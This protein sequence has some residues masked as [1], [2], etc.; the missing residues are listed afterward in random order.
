MCA[1]PYGSDSVSLFHLFHWAFVYFCSH[2]CCNY[3]AILKLRIT[4]RWA[5]VCCMRPT[6]LPSQYM[7]AFT[8]ELHKILTHI[9]THTALI[10][11]CMLSSIVV[12]AIG[13]PI[14]DT[15]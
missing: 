13:A 2:F 15:H 11:I 6:S 9:C 5:S 3:V 8:H 7:S 12:L 14:S 1:P 4:D 10:L